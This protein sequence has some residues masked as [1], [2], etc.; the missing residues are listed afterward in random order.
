MLTLERER[1]IQKEDDYSKKENNVKQRDLAWGIEIADEDIA[2]GV[3]R[4]EMTASQLAMSAEDDGQRVNVID[5]QMMMERNFG[6]EMTDLT[7]NGGLPIWKLDALVT[8]LGP[9]VDVTRWKLFVAFD[10]FSVA[11]LFGRE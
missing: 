6:G 3:F 9:L 1:W 4:P 7:P 10:Y 2:G 5:R 8:W 11:K